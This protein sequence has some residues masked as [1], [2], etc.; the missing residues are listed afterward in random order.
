MKKLIIFGGNGFLGRAL[1]QT[2]VSNNFQVTSIS[3]SGQPSPEEIWMTQVTWVKADVFQ[4]E[5]WQELLKE[6]DAVINAIGILVEK[7]A[8]GITYERFN[9]QAA[10]II[11]KAANHAGVK[12]LVYVSA[13]PFTKLLS[14][15]FHSKKSAEIVTRTYFPS[16]LLIRPNFMYGKNRRG[17]I[18]QARLITLA[19]KIPI[20]TSVF[21]GLQPQAVEKVA[22]Q[23]LAQL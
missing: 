23:I 14:R 12:T 1:A 11:A 9:V 21:K 7:K 5:T 6:A 10:K 4:P 16:A 17:T 19:K 18:T 20:L 3:R 2:A 13:D 15:Y 22:Q 8:K